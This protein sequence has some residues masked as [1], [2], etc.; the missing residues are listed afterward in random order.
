[1]DESEGAWRLGLLFVSG[2]SISTII[3]DR[4][5]CNFDCLKEKT[6][7]M[8]IKQVS[9]SEQTPQNIYIVSQK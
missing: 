7:R 9:M 8:Q 6:I 1:M 5:F 3:I 4:I 2:N